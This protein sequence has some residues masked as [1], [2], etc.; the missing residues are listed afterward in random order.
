MR[1]WHH[2][3]FTGGRHVICCLQYLFGVNEE[4]C[5]GALDLHSRK[6]YLFVPKPPDSYATWMGPMAVSDPRVAAAG[7]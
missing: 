5:Y 7:S 6:S 1:R 4:D 3:I 2:A